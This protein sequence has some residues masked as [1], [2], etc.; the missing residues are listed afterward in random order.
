MGLNQNTTFFNSVPLRDTSLLVFIVV[1]LIS[2]LTFQGYVTAWC[3]EEKTSSAIVLLKYFTKDFKEDWKREADIAQDLLCGDD[4]HGNL[5]HYRWHAKGKKL[6]IICYTKW[7]EI[8]FIS[9]TA[10]KILPAHLKYDLEKDEIE[11]DKQ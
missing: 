8:F 2:H 5:L 3:K 1:S 4:P 7:R 6:F 11:S 9:R 10:F